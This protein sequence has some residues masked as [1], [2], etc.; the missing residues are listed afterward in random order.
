MKEPN[1]SL[2]VGCF[3]HIGFF[4]KALKEHFSDGWNW[5][6]TAIL[7]LSLIATGIWASIIS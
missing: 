4:W 3:K 6:D 7:I 1:D 5:I 2:Y